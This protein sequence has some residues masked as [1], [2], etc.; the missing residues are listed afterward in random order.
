MAPKAKRRRR[1]K[2]SVK[3]VADGSRRK[4]FDSVQV[5]VRKAFIGR[6]WL[7]RGC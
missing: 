2:P 4:S 3:N 1:G 6:T 5:S 7:G